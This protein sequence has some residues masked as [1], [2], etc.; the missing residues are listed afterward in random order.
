MYKAKMDFSHPATGVVKTGD[1]VPCDPKEAAL[2][3]ATGKLEYLTK[4]L[5]PAPAGL[6]SASMSS[7]PARRRKTKTLPDSEAE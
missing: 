7:R 6:E 5:H 1:E 3:V 4:V 2:L